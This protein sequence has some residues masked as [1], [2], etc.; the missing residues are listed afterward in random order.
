MRW[1]P[2]LPVLLAALIAPPPAAAEGRRNLPGAVFSTVTAPLRIIA[3][4]VTGR[5][6]ARSSRQQRAYAKHPRPAVRSKQAPRAAAVA[7][8]AIAPAIGAAGAES[9]QRTPELG[10]Q[11]MAPP[12]AAAMGA[13]APRDTRAPTARRQWMAAT[14]WLGPLY[15]PYASD[16]L[17][18]YVLS[19]SSSG[20]WFWA[21]GAG[22]LFDAIFMRTGDNKA[23]WEDMCGGRRGG[24]NVWLEPIR[25]AV[26]PNAP[27]LEALNALRDALVKAGNEIRTA[28]PTPDTVA[29]PSQ[30]IET[31][32]D[33]LWALRQ[34]TIILAPPLE[35]FVNSLTR[36]QQ[37]RL[38]AIKNETVSRPI[39]ASNAI[40]AQA[41]AQAC[42]VPASPFADWPADEIERRVRPD[43]EQRQAVETLRLTTL[44]MTQ[45]LMESCPAEPPDTPLAR[46]AAADKRLDALLYAARVVAPTLHGFHGLLAEEQ[47]TAFEAIGRQ[48]AGRPPAGAAATVGRER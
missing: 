3:G 18:D 23:A 48:P 29:T 33:R 22:D 15:W 46:L 37:A 16:D 39:T 1:G 47:R 13:Q 30:R 19:P 10:T 11:A 12:A 8:A 45:M 24:S 35:A 41:N 44:G 34:A 21:R 6:V 20:D 42:S 43:D 9:A 5:R 32:K 40:G 25:Q 38:N 36:N 14:G 7:P 28:C 26:E 17:F 4:A 2:I 27:Q 31:M